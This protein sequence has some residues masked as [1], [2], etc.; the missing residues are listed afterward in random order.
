[1]ALDRRRPRTHVVPRREGLRSRNPTHRPTS[2]NYNLLFDI[3]YILAWLC[4]GPGSTFR[5]AI[6]PA[7]LA[8]EHVNNIAF[9]GKPMCQDTL[10][11]INSLTRVENPTIP[12]ASLPT[13]R[14]SMEGHD[15]SFTF[16]AAGFELHI[17][18]PPVVTDQQTLDYAARGGISF[19][20]Q[21]LT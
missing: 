7:T 18:R 12:G 14:W 19:E 4:E 16:D 11:D 9:E 15:G 5:F 3:D 20:E 6:S 17:R 13:Y 1:M 8:F 10:L 2:F 21:Q